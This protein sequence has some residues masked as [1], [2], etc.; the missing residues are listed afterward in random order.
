MTARI[1]Y[2]TPKP[3]PI[4]HFIR[5]GSSGHRQL[6]TLHSSGRLPVSRVVAEAASLKAQGELLGSLRNGGA[7]IT[8]DTRIA[9]LSEPGSY[10]PSAQ[11]LA[12]AD[13]T[14]PMTPRDF[15]GD[16][17]R[18]IAAQ[19]ATCAVANAVHSVLVPS[20]FVVECW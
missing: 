12:S 6:E 5:I 16:G 17:S 11:W 8:L 3:E 2:L 15:S 18:R 7:E 10:V 9:E 1:H 20:H 13:K 4:G 14:R 19:V